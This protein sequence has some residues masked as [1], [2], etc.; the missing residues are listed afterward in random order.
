MRH[1]EH[2]FPQLRN[3][4]I[5][6]VENRHVWDVR[7]ALRLVDGLQLTQEQLKPLI[8]AGVLQ[9]FNVLQQ[10][11]CWKRFASDPQKGTERVGSRVTQT[12]RIAARPV[13]G[14]RERL[15]RRPAGD[16]VRFAF[17]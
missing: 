15:T 14:L 1:D 4:K 5:R 12:Q 9:S 13:A 10:N 16:D 3:T 7:S 11:D 6:R 17:L 8:L 2:A